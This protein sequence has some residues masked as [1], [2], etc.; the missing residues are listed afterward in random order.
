MLSDSDFSFFGAAATQG[1]I[2]PTQ[3]N[4]HMKIAGIRFLLA[5]DGGKQNF[6][7][8]YPIQSILFDQFS[9]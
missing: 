1:E 6:Q 8:S 3:K 9:K 2:H 7:G 5:K 4:Q